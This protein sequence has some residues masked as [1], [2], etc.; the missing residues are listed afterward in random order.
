MNAP[1]GQRALDGELERVVNDAVGLD[2]VARMM[3][4]R[5]PKKCAPQ[6]RIGLRRAAVDW[7]PPPRES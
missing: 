4:V 3:P 7:R 2:Q 5:D 6:K 1:A